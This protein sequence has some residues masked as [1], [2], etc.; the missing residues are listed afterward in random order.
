M[1]QYYVTRDDKRS[2]RPR[3]LSDSQVKLLTSSGYK[4]VPVKET[5]QS[6]PEVNA[7]R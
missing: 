4:L 7:E 3:A 6:T 1:K 5:E 2:K